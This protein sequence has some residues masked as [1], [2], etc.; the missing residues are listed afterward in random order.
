[1]SEGSRALADDLSVLF[2]FY[3][4]FDFMA[5]PFPVKM[6]DF[7]TVNIHVNDMEKICEEFI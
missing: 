3:Y 2:S 5:F 6:T 7:W 4:F 1:M